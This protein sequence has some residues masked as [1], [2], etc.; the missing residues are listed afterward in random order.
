M[1]KHFTVA[2]HK[3]KYAYPRILFCFIS[4]REKKNKNTKSIC[5]SR[6]P[7]DGADGEE[8]EKIKHSVSQ[9]ALPWATLTL[10]QSLTL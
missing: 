3:I 7:T 8:E 5:N 10:T 6:Y 9:F 4:L 1:S 2:I